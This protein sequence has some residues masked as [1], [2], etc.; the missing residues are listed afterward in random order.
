MSPK[1]MS[2]KEQFLQAWEAEWPI[3]LEVLKAFPAAKGEFKPAE[4]SRSARELAWMFVLHQQVIDR[5]IKGQMDLGKTQQPPPATWDEVL[6]TFEK[7]GAETTRKLK[8]VHDEAFD[9]IIEFPVGPGKMGAVRVGQAV[10]MML[11]DGVHHRG[12][13][14][15]YLRMV[16]AKVP[17]IYGPSLD[18]PWS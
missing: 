18:E 15:V 14:S 3:T 1:T 11:M 5:A 7:M 12:Q 6:R 13:F 9:K 17:S 10:W 4:K 2:E 8:A 16:G